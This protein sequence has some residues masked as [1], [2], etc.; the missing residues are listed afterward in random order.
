[1][2]G[3]GRVWDAFAKISLT[4]D[5]YARQALI[6]RWVTLK[7]STPRSS[8]AVSFSEYHLRAAGFVISRIA[9]PTIMNKLIYCWMSQ[10][11]H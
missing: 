5:V 11:G 8:K 4:R 9:S 10:K 6:K 3:D 7:A 1:M 2:E